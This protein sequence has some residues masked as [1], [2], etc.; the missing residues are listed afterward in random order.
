MSGINASLATIRPV[1]EHEATG[2]LAEIFADIKR[3]KKIDF[4]PRFW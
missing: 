4:V 1:E 2:K 3:T